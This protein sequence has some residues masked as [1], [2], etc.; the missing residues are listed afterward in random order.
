MKDKIIIREK[1][2][3]IV[4]FAAIILLLFFILALSLSYQ[5]TITA[6]VVREI[7]IDTESISISVKEFD[8]VKELNQLNEGW[9]QVINGYVFYLESFDSYIFLYTKVKNPEE[10]NGLLVV[11]ADGNIKFDETFNGLPGRQVAV[12]YEEI[13][14]EE[15][16]EAKNQ[17]TGEVTGMEGVSGF[18]TVPCPPQL[19]SIYSGYTMVWKQ[20][21]GCDY[22]FSDNNGIIN[23]K[24]DSSKGLVVTG[25]TDKYRTDDVLKTWAR[26]DDLYEVSQVPP[27]PPRPP[28]PT[29]PPAPAPSPDRISI[30]GAS[31]TLANDGNHYYKQCSEEVKRTYYVTLVDSFGKVIH[32]EVSAG[33]P[34]LAR[35]EITQQIQNTGVRI[36]SISTR[37]PSGPAQPRTESE[38]EVTYIG[39]GSVPV[40]T[41]GKI[42]HFD[43]KGK[44]PNVFR[45]ELNVEIRIANAYQTWRQKENLPDTQDT[46]ELFKPLV[47][48]DISTGLIYDASLIDKA[49]NIPPSATATAKDEPKVIRQITGPD[50]NLIDA[51][52]YNG[53]IIKS[54]EEY[55]S[56]STRLHAEEALKAL[57]G[58]TIIG[59][60]EKGLQ[61]AKKGNDIFVFNPDKKEFVQLDTSKSEEQSYSLT[62][63]IG[64][65]NDVVIVS[66]TF[67]TQTQKQTEIKITKGDK[68]AIVDED[69]AKEV[70]DAK[71][72][73]ISVDIIQEL[74][75]VPSTRLEGVTEDYKT[76]CR[77]NPECNSNFEGNLYETKY[78][79]DYKAETNAEPLHIVPSERQ[80]LG[81]QI[82]QFKKDNIVVGQITFSADYSLTKGTKEIQKFETIFLD[83]NNNEITPEK[84]KELEGKGET[85]RPVQVRTFWRE[86][87]KE[88]GKV[89]VTFYSI[90]LEKG[91]EV[92]EG[93]KR[94]AEGNLVGF[95]YVEKDIVAGGEEKVVFDKNGNIV[96][97][98]S[99]KSEIV[100]SK[101][102]TARKQHSLSQFFSEFQ[103]I[104]TEFRGLG[105]YA[106]L[107]FDE[108]SLLAWRDNVDRAFA[109]LYLGTEY[110][111]SGLCSQ[112]IDGE[113]EGVAYAETPQGLA[114]IG[115]HIEAT[116]T[117]AI[118]TGT[119]QEFI[120][121]IT[122]SIRNGDFAKDP[123]A[124]EEMNFNVVLRGERTVNVFKQD[125]KVERGSS[126]SRTGRSAIVQEST[127]LFTQVCILFDEIPLRWKLDNKELCNSIVEVAGEA[128]PLAATTTTTP[129]A[130]TGAAE[131]EVNDF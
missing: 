108:D 105:Y 83:K 66:R 85:T 97:E 80:V 17:I 39:D 16:E 11:D 42:S 50:G 62:E 123:R 13:V 26:I 121:K 99:T 82:I 74:S 77:G 5:S 31:Y 38:F 23:A 14:E 72:R 51:W 34:D 112:Y 113:D 63:K 41:N 24:Y 119:G 130:G 8:D 27:P 6:N 110:I 131:G 1:A 71:G 81:N 103:R 12:Y 55:V 104:F 45:D 118:Q 37:P 124:P 52:F 114:Q 40:V 10:R 46:K 96:E 102:G 95:I 33:T 128:T 53:K 70:K 48:A 43:F 19:Q 89:S 59:I 79:N 58:G 36:T 117:Q 107:F 94:D 75:K 98:K 18:A 64:T 90:R 69:T 125:Q 129:A 109:T 126:F 101:A 35:A 127:T 93:T 57:K 67:E 22:A 2:R 49:L 116:R 61:I 100:R 78:Q 32:D 84:A 44:E 47:P 92:S 106:T 91:I 28:A 15:T 9:Y 3:G 76:W 4:S 7:S 21:S 120:Y 73:G 56:I 29:A 25:A 20:V 115:A 65:G 86:E 122:F 54:R 87:T 88:D 111:S 60:N 68:S 30:G